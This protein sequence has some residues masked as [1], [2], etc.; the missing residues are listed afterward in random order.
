MLIVSI[1]NFS[2]KTQSIVD[3]LKNINGIY[4]IRTD[5]KVK[6]NYKIIGLKKIP[7]KKYYISTTKDHLSRL[8]IWS[9]YVAL[10]CRKE[11]KELD[12]L[13]DHCVSNNIGIVSDVFDEDDIY[14][15]IKYKKIV[16][17]IATTF[18]FDKKIKEKCSLI[19]YAKRK[20]F[21]VIAEG[22]YKDF[23]D[24]KKALL[25][26][27]SYVCIGQAIFDYVL[28]TKEYAKIF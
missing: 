16:K 28:R 21:T 22:G 12:C 13:L 26:G 9:D 7:N 4:A 19:N 3:S 8:A 14:N 2:K 6:T 23:N 25:A 24:I 5:T 20:G 17:Y 18:H 15:L 27:A 11:N 1:Q 10:D